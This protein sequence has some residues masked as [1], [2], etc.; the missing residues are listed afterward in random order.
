MLS[1]KLDYLVICSNVKNIVKY[2]FLIFSVFWYL[3]IVIIFFFE[4]LVCYSVF[5]DIKS[6][7]FGFL[8]G[9]FII[10]LDKNYVIY[11]RVIWNN[12]SF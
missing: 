1:G 4:K 2:N 3:Y 5:F 8:G 9:V 11:I 7:N 10:F 12:N 6:Y